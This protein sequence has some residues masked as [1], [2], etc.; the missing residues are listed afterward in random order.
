MKTYWRIDMNGQINTPTTLPLG[1]QLWVPIL[2][3]DVWAPDLI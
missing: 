1:A 3:E 2:Y